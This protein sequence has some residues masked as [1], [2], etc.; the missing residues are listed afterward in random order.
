MTERYVA[1]GRVLKPHGVQGEIKV[2][3]L[4]DDPR[5]FRR[6][7]RVFC[8]LPDGSR[9]ELHVIGA[10]MAGPDTVLVRF[11]EIPSPEAALALRDGVLE[12]PRSESPPLPPGKVYYADMIGLEACEEG[13]ERPLGHVTAIISAAQELLEITTPGGEEL[14]VPWVPAWVSRIDLEAGR[15]WLTPVPGWREGG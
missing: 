10:R 9:R 15:V 2:A 7:D 11:R 8:R 5:R 1:I 13:A 4:T 3:P 14:M 12:I 6:L